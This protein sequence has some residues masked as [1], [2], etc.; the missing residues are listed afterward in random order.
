MACDPLEGYRA[1][2]DAELH[3]SLK[4]EQNN[5]CWRLMKAIFAP[6]HVDPRHLQARRERWRE[7]YYG[8]L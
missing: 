4:R 3:P 6:D 7:K 2:L 8:N 5:A 1:I